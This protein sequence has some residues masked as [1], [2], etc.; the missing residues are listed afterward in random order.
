MSQLVI[1]LG[2][3]VELSVDTPSNVSPVDRTFLLTSIIT[4]RCLASPTLSG[5]ST[6]NILFRIG[7]EVF[8]IRYQLKVNKV[9]KALSL[10]S[11]AIKY[12]E[13]NPSL[14]DARLAHKAIST[15][16]EAFQ[17]QLA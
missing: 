13:S 6:G 11:E 14:Y 15:L 5:L 12:I 8:R 3:D 17:N 9:M 1:N 2:K 10:Y 7:T 16:R 4:E